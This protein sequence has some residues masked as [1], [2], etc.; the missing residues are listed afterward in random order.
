MPPKAT[1]PPPHIHLLFNGSII[2][3]NESVKYLGITIDKK[4]NFKIH[5]KLESKIFRS[6]GI[7]T[8]LRHVLLVKALRTLY[9][10]MIHPHLLYGIAIWGTTFTSY[11]KRLSI[12]RNRA[13]KQIVGCHWQRNANPCYAQ[14]NIV[15]LNDLYTHETAKLMFK[16]AYKTTPIAFSSFFTPVISIHTRTTRL[17]SYSKN[18]N[19]QDTKQ[20]KC[21]EV[22]NFKGLKFGTLYLNDLRKLS[23]NQF[24]MK[25]KECYLLTIEV[26]GL[27]K[28]FSLIYCRTA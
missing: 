6:I 22:S 16:H 17:A 24:K 3:I 20:T 13:I 5:I 7:M 19:C 2:P 14:L 27:Q 8:K 25:Y 11:L 12:F 10:S 18:L 1:S 9:Y 21:K 28:Y 26:S 23:F 4:L 15:K